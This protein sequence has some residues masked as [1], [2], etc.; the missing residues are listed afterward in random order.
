VIT[1]PPQVARELLARHQRLVV[2]GDVGSGK[3]TLL[4][5]LAHDAANAWLQSGTG[6]IP[7]LL[8]ATKLGAQALRA[9]EASL[10]ETVGEAQRED[11][12][13]DANPARR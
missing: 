8:S 7:I 13:F 11:T 6:R 10:A 3:S 4:K 5:R 2:V 12:R 1:A 9:P